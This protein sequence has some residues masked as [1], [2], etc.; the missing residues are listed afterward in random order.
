MRSL[1]YD[2]QRTVMNLISLLLPPRYLFKCS[3][4]V[5]LLSC[6]FQ[7]AHTSICI[8]HN[9]PLFFEIYGGSIP[10]VAILKRTVEGIR[11]LIPK[12]EIIH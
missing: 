6:P 9:M 1:F 5:F 2:I 8:F 3:K 12:I 4:D 7:F 11:K 10:D